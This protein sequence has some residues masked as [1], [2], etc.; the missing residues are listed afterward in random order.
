MSSFISYS[1]RLAL[2]I[3][4]FNHF[5]YATMPFDE[6]FSNCFSLPRDTV[7]NNEFDCKTSVFEQSNKEL[8]KE[9]EKLK[10]YIYKNYDNPWRLNDTEGAGIE[11]KDIFWER[12]N[13]SQKNWLVSRDA[14]CAA[15]AAL[16]GSW[17]SAAGDIEISCIITMNK[18]RIDE[19][20]MLYHPTLDNP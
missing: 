8:E 14:F 11:I 3:G 12:F 20:N 18:R 1:A 16:P 5:S 13:V 7:E 4:V 15:E 6:T 2:V 17:A 19:I 10:A 9:K